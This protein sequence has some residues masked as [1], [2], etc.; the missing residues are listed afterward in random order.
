MFQIRTLEYPEQGPK[1]S[2]F[3]EVTPRILP[4]VSIC[5]DPIAASHG[6][7]FFGSLLC[8][9]H[10]RPGIILGDSR[11]PPQVPKAMAFLRPE[12]Y[13]TGRSIVSRGVGTNRSIRHESIELEGFHQARPFR[14][15][16]L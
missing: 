5:H 14:A 1:L 11:L 12:F 10:R 7:K 15:L 13:A 8:P 9:T 16:H 6:I 2:A 3:C 4:S